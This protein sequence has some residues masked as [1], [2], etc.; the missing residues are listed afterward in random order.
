MP[1]RQI[2]KLFRK[3]GKTL[4]GNMCQ[5]AQSKRLHKYYLSLQVNAGDQF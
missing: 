4:Q 2:C 5:K 3:A 1:F